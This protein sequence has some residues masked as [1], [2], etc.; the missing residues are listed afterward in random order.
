MERKD[1]S[2]HPLATLPVEAIRE[3]VWALDLHPHSFSLHQD[4]IHDDDLFALTKKAIRLTPVLERVYLCSVAP[5][6]GGVTRPNG[7]VW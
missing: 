2:P 1:W 6:N 7:V 4:Y 3:R 5:V